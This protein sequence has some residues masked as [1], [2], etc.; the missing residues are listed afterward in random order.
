MNTDNKIIWMF[1]LL[2]GQSAKMLSVLWGL[3]GVPWQMCVWCTVHAWPL[4]FLFLK[5][6]LLVTS[7]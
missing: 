6:S 4:L 1:G 2:S 3:D 7:G 5:P